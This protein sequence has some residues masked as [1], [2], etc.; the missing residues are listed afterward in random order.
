MVMSSLSYYV[1]SFPE[2]RAVLVREQASSLYDVSPYFF[3][4]VIAEIPFSLPHPLIMILLVYWFVPLAASVKAFFILFA[5]MVLEYQAG[6]SYSLLL[7]AFIT[8]RESLINI[9]PL[10]QMPLMMLS[11]FFVDLDEVVP[12]LWP[13]QWISMLKYT[14]NIQLRNEF[15]NNDKLNIMSDGKPMTTEVLLDMSGVDMGITSS[16]LCLLAV[17][18]GFLLIALGGLI[19]TTKRV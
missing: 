12:V 6:S 5:S 19:F 2:E 14:F 11:G 7:G 15:E 18:I 17:Y 10:I 13:F 1:L 3:A 8:D 4:K 9:A 16:F